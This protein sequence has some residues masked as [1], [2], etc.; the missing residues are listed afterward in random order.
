VI[1]FQLHG[2]RRDDAP[3]PFRFD[4]GFT[5]GGALEDDVLL[6]DPEI[7]P[8]HAEVVVENDTYWLLHA[9]SRVALRAGREL[10][11]GPYK[12]TVQ[13]VDGSWARHDQGSKAERA[14]LNRR[15]REWEREQELQRAQRA[16]RETPFVAR[17]EIEAALLHALRDNPQDDA[18]LEVYSDYLEQAG[19]AD[20]A[21]LARLALGVAPGDEAGLRERAPAREAMWRA[22]VL[23]P[24]IDRCVGFESKC[25]E[26]W[27]RMTPTAADDV[28]HCGVCDRPVVFCTSLKQAGE[29]GA[30][31]AC[32]AIDVTMTRELACIHYDD[33]VESMYGQFTVG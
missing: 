1:Y 6:L 5:I 16:A 9:G 29:L 22:L 13:L 27:D 30:R 28:R 11:L 17:T 31:H 18:T 12:I 32:I 4:S 14:A 3:T 25:P 26:R 20:Q 19:H 15:R 8:A 23:R 21:L 2:P 33:D 10:A 24:P 7:R